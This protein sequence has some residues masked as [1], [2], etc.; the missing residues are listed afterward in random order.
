MQDDL[1]F[2]RLLDDDG[3]VARLLGRTRSGRQRKPLYG[4]DLPVVFL[5]GGP[6]MGKGRLLGCVRHDFGRFVPTAHLDCGAPAVTE[7]VAQRPELRSEVTEALREMALQFGK[8]QGT[9]G[10]L[11]APR[12]YAGLLAVATS[13]RRSS[14]ESLVSEVRE[15]DGLLPPGT[16]WRGV[17]SRAVRGYL[18]ALGGLVATPAAVPIISAVLDELLARMSREGTAALKRCYGEYPGAG[19][20]PELGLHTLAAHFQQGGQGRENAEKFLFRALREDIEAAH[21]SVTGRMTR[22]GRPALLL[23]RADNTLGRR[24]TRAVLEDRERG[25]HDRLVVLATA[26]REDGGRFLH[27]PGHA[28]EGRAATWQPADG[29][30]PTWSRSPVGDPGLASPGRGAL[31]VRMPLLTRDQQEREIARTQGSVGTGAGGQGLPVGPGFPGSGPSRL[32]VETGIRR[33]SGGRPLFVSRLAEATA[34]FRMP[35]EGS[36]WDLLDAPAGTRDEQEEHA[37]ADVLLDDLVVRQLPEELPPEQREHW[38]DLL[39]H[40]SVAHD[41]DCAQAL[42][43]ERQAEREERLSAYRIAELLRDCGW[44]H[45]PRHF[46]GDLGLRHLLA[47]RLYGTRAGGAAWREDHTFLRDRLAGEEEGAPDALFGTAAAHRMHH[48]LA[49]DG[50]GN[51]HGAPGAEA[52]TNYLA[53]TFYTRETRDWCGE[54]LAIADVPLLGGPDDRRARALGAGGTRGGAFHRRVDKLLHVVWLCE[55]RARTVDDAVTSTLRLLLERLSD[56]SE[57]GAEVLTRVAGEWSE[58]AGNKQA[59]LPC[60]C[61]GHIR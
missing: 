46:I 39:S 23:D 54:L 16:F 38:L 58:R 22:V 53:R 43:R 8:W 50:A 1:G 28:D 44:P 11:P 57:H 5:V 10:A 20:S 12:L 19:G 34:A 36:D 15:Q 40:L 13:D 32:R 18:A 37:V 29:G 45:C 2:D 59:L 33:L 61:T 4:P 41:A 26:R 27:P 49:A 9:G 48:H 55:D 6:G 17:L 30:L 31:L 56:E 35:E 52:V 25:H 21:T 42:M 24:L 14:T 47:R 51:G 60:A 3:F 7:R